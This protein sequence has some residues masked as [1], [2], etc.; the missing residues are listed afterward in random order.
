MQ[1]VHQIWRQ[2]YEKQQTKDPTK[3]KANVI[4][5]PED[6]RH[7]TLQIKDLIPN[8]TALAKTGNIRSLLLTI[9]DKTVILPVQ[10]HHL[11]AIQPQSPSQNI[12]LKSKT[13][14]HS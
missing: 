3:T 11:T 14:N 7:I 2:T 9:P 5:L 12:S 6:K 4:I 10:R 8:R 1:R 13:N